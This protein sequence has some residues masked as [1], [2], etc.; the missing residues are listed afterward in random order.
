[1]TIDLGHPPVAQVAEGAADGARVEA[2]DVASERPKKCALG[3][4]IG[5]LD[6][7]AHALGKCTSEVE[8][9][10]TPSCSASVRMILP[11]SVIASFAN[12]AISFYAS[13]AVPWNRPLRNP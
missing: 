4:R 3:G 11:Q 9:S 1:M 13:C 6:A 5:D 12:V 8:G 2:D 7:G 10:V